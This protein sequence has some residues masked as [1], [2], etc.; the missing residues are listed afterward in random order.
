MHLVRPSP[1]ADL[2]Q[3][4][5]RKGW[6]ACELIQKEWGEDLFWRVWDHST[7]DGPLLS[8]KLL[9]AQLPQLSRCSGHGCRC[10]QQPGTASLTASG[11]PGRPGGAAAKPC[12]C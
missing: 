2:W 1:L 9:L 11:R 12:K 8:F 4:A 3:V 10:G 7:K 6:A 5:L